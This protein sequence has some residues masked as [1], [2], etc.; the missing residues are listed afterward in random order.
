MPKGSLEPLAIGE[1]KA[2]LTMTRI[3]LLTAY[4][5]TTILTIS[6]SRAGA[7]DL[8]EPQDEIILTVSGNIQA[9]NVDGHAVF[10]LAMLKQLPV[11]AFRTTTIWTEGTNEFTGVL[12]SDLLNAVGGEGNQ[13]KATAINDYAVDIPISDAVDG[14][15][16][17]AYELDG[18]SMPVREKGPLWIVYPYD[19]NSSYRTETVYSRSIWQL[20]DIV[21]AD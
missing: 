20:R 3:L 13:I 2:D 12:L 14:G 21:I 15:P 18:K 16:I 19:A 4:F 6:G 10:D 1:A 17:I 11:T 9:T 8:P 7:T 5:L